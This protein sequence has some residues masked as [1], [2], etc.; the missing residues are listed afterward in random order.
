MD[1]DVP[2]R[3][4]P[5]PPSLPPLPC[6]QLPEPPGAAGLGSASFPR[7][8]KPLLLGAQDREREQGVSEPTIKLHSTPNLTSYHEPWTIQ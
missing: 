5:T 8:W 4:R 3:L 2:P 7:V 6:L 1:E